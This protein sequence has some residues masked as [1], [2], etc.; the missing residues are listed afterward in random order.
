M[1]YN[2]VKREL[3]HYVHENGAKRELDARPLRKGEQF[4]PII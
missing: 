2:P 4:H 1:I 3:E